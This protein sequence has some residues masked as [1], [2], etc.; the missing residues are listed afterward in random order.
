M[1]AP[2]TRGVATLAGQIRLALLSV[3][4]VAILIA[5]VGALVVGLPCGI[6][7]GRLAWRMYAKIGRAHV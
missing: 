7:L 3:T 4:L 2:E 6:V 5:T 1:S